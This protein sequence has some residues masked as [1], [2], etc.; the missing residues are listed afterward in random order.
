MPSL[1]NQMEI[2]NC[3]SRIHTLQLRRQALQ[4]E[5]HEIWRFEDEQRIDT[6]QQFHPKEI[7]RIDGEIA[8]LE[9]RIRQLS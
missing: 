8:D 9:A 3:Y 7:A 2:Q 1:E 5:L 4:N 6:G